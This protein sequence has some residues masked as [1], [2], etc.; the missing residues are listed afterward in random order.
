MVDHYEGV[1]RADAERDRALCGFVS[2]VALAGSLSALQTD[3]IVTSDAAVV[4]AGILVLAAVALSITWR[5]AAMRPAAPRQGL[6]RDAS[7]DETDEVETAT[8]TSSSSARGSEGAPTGSAPPGEAADVA[9]VM[10][11]LSRGLASLASGD[12]TARIAVAFPAQ[13]EELRDGFNDAMERNA[14][15]I[16][17]ARRRA[18]SEPVMSPTHLAPPAV[19]TRLAPPRRVAKVDLFAG[20]MSEFI[21]LRDARASTRQ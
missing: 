21:E 13:Y 2:L 20:R 17:R 19:V 9:V 11:E 16:A 10:R 18:V 1:S 8:S 14:G 7:A 4:L 5:S 3:G 15:T 12:L 6:V